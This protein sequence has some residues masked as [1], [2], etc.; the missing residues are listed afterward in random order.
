[1]ANADQPRVGDILMSTEGT[2]HSVSIFPA[3][4]QLRFASMELAYRVAQR[5][6]LERKARLWCSQNGELFQL[7]RVEMARRDAE[8]EVPRAP[9]EVHHSPPL[10]LFGE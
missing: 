8:P 4:A 2:W 10:Q 3:V 7:S 1:M 5:F 6:A 9:T